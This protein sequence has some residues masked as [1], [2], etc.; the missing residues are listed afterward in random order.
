VAFPSASGSLKAKLDEGADESTVLLVFFA[1]L[2]PFA[3][4]FLGHELCFFGL[5]VACNSASGSFNVKP[6]EH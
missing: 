6:F 2:I 5:Q 4:F 3:S 1:R